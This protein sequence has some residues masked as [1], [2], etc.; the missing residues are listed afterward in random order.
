MLPLQ[1]VG[2]TSMVDAPALSRPRLINS[3]TV[4]RKCGEV[5]DMTLHR[6]TRDRNFPKPDVVIANRK[7]WYENA[8]DAW[9]DAQARRGRPRNAAD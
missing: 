4:R 1:R 2:S 3:N 7:F 6:W 5:S 8:V 9:I